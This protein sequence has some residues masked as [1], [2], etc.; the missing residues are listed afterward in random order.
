MIRLP[1]WWYSFRDAFWA[2]PDYLSGGRSRRYLFFTH[3]DS[4]W[5][6][7][8]ARRKFTLPAILMIPAAGIILL[9]AL[10]VLQSP[11][12]PLVFLMLG[13][14]AVTLV[15][16]WFFRPRGE[17]V[18]IAPSRVRAGETFSFRY[19]IRSTRYIR[20]FDLVC[21]PFD[22]SP[23]LECVSR[24]ELASL[25]ARTTGVCEAQ[26]RARRRGVI[27]LY[28]PIAESAF[29]LGLVKWSIRGRDP[30]ELIVWPAFTPLEVLALPR[31]AA[32]R[33]VGSTA[34]AL[35]G[36]SPD[37]LGSRDFRAGDAI[38]HID[39]PGSARRGAL[40]VKEFAREEYMRIA[41]IADTCPGR[42]LYSADP[43]YPELEAAMSLAAAVADNLLR[44]GTEVDVLA[45]GRQIHRI[46]P[47]R[48]GSGFQQVCDILAAVRPEKEFPAAELSGALLPELH[49]TAA[50]VLLLLADTPDRRDLA[51]RI[52]QT[53]MPLKTVL[54]TDTAP[55]KGGLPPGWR[56]IRPSEVLS[57]SVSSL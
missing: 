54:L 52:A 19:E 40:V 5:A 24:A 6:Y 8:L 36:E 18:R 35:P 49:E 1:G 30:G 39:W 50:A 31:A 3:A 45:A 26:V 7:G 27:R 47:G 4:V 51:D 42:R 55:K 44:H 41:V 22:W 16:G 10:I 20:V 48:H 15:T 29:P 37:L 28:R 17:L 25:P 34:A 53:G 56:H 11:M 12:M 13:A 38:R 32:N 14:G 43:E 46:R 9:Y 57:G 21:D 33:S 23:G 2:G